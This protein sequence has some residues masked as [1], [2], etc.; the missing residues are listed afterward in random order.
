MRSTDSAARWA[1]LVGNF[2]IG[3]GVLAPAGLINDLSSAFAVDVATVGELMAYG[4]A[5]LCVEAPLFAFVTNR[6]DRRTLLTGA[7]IFYAA[8]H[9]ASAWAPS[10]GVLLAIRV[11]MIGGAAIFTPQAASAVGLIAAPERRS[12]GVAFI[13]LGWSLAGAVGI[14]I[15]SLIGAHVGWASAYLILGIAGLVA[16]V[17]VFCTLPAG[18][19]APRLSGAIWIGVVF[20]RRML[21]ILAVTAIFVAGQFTQFPY[22]A[23]ELKRRLDA[24]PELIAGFLFLFGFA[25][26][27]GSMASTAVIDR[28]GAPKTATIGLAVVLIGL[29]LWS[30]S[31]A[32]VVLA[33][34]GLTIWGSGGSPVVSAQQARVIAADANSASASVALN[35]SVL[36]AGQAIGTSIGGQLTARAEHVLIGVAGITLILIALV[37]SS[38][39]QVPKGR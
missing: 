2:V 24:S 19:T 37:V 1:L 34:I 28:L 26:V 13:F 36:Y 18:L 7:L 9:L 27:L 6:I 35:S 38:I 33:G 16:A 15:A 32:S 30:V 25:G 14:P 4:A 8:G 21:L 29:A 39:S 22:V 11:V 12:S 20:N 3:T 31:G 5:V 23:A 17:A 10:F